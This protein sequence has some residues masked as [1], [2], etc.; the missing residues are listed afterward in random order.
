MLVPSHYRRGWILVRGPAIRQ[1][2]HG[3]AGIIGL[4]WDTEDVPR[5][6]CGQL[7]IGRARL[8]WDTHKM[9]VRRT[10]NVRLVAV[11]SGGGRAHIRNRRETARRDRPGA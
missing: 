11:R 4:L 6:T 5:K 9:S 2:G 8:L 7:P 1:G 3:A 10:R